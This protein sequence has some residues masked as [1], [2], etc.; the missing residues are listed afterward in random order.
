[1]STFVPCDKEVRPN[2][3]TTTTPRTLELV[4]IN[5]TLNRPDVEALDEIAVQLQTN[6]SA[7]VRTALQQFLQR[8]ERLRDLPP[9]EGK[10]KAT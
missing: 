2:M 8:Q 1:M 5:V 10:Q 7:L 4:P 6:R 3:E 9:R